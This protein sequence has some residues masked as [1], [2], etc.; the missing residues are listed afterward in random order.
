MLGGANRAAAA[1]AAAATAAAAAAAAADADGAA[2]AV[3]SYA[4]ITKKSNGLLIDASSALFG[5]TGLRCAPAT[6]FSKSSYSTCCLTARILAS[7]TCCFRWSCSS[8]PSIEDWSESMA[9]ACL[10]GVRKNAEAC[11]ARSALLRCA[12]RSKPTA[13]PIT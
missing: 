8:A 2:A 10:C 3:A 13:D 9:R 11:A 7:F 5:L 6:S 12:P 4:G 1:G